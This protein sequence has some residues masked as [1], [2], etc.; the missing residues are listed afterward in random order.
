LLT[1]GAFDFAADARG[2]TWGLAVEC[3]L[4]AWAIRAGRFLGPRNSNGLALDFHVFTHYGDNL[5]IEHAHNIHG[6]PGRVRLLGFRNHERMGAFADAVSAA[7]ASGGTPALEGVRRDQ[8]KLGF[9]VAVEQYLGLD[10][11]AFLRGSWN[12]GRTETYSFTEIDRSLAIGASM[13]GPVW[14]RPG[15][16]VGV[17]WVMNGLSDSHRDFLAKGGL[18][19]FIGDGQLDY[20]PEQIVE[21]YYSAVTFR[22]LW[23]TADYQHVSNPAYNADRGPAN[24]L[25]VRLHLEM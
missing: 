21:V 20:R 11:T 1:H 6:W 22:G 5:E 3:Y 24:F 9:G 25:G 17:A 10:A 2:Y 13:R 7:S 14:R 4:D 23:L 12:D 18:G 19:F 15:D 16:T 8:S